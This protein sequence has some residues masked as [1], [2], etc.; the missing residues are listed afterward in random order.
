M[1]TSSEEGT[2]IPDKVNKNKCQDLSEEVNKQIQN[3]DVEKMTGI[4]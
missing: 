3:T 4:N 1:D 2:Q